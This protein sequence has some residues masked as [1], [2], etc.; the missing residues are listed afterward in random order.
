MTVTW[1]LHVRCLN[2]PESGINCLNRAALEVLEGYYAP[3][4]IGDLNY[5]GALL[6]WGCPNPF[7]CL[8]GTDLGNDSCY[9]TVT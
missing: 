8:G 9:M 5:S 1:L 3:R 7:A 2:C 4:Y 6:A